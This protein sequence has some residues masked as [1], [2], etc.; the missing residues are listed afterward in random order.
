MFTTK[1]TKITK[2]MPDSKCA[3]LRVLRALRVE[4]FFRHLLPA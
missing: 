1:D 4:K 2:R 3:N